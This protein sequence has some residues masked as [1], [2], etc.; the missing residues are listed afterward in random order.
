[1]LRSLIL[2][3]SSALLLGSCAF[4]NGIVTSGGNPPS[5]NQQLVGLGTGTST[6]T[7]V[8]GF[9]GLNKDALVLEAKKN[10]Y[11]NTRLKPNQA[12]TNFTVDFR[13]GFFPFVRRIKVT[14]AADIIQTVDGPVNTDDV[15]PLHQQIFDLQ[16][17]AESN[18]LL[19]DD[20]WVFKGSKVEAGVLTGFS[21][22]GNCIVR[23]T[24]QPI[25]RHRYYS[26]KSVFLME[27]S[28]ERASK[29][30]VRINQSVQIKYPSGKVLDAIVMGVNDSGALLMDKDRL[31][32]RPYSEVYESKGSSMD[33]Q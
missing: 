18:F 11:A 17:P 13:Y 27:I 28:E 19:G 5:P 2:L 31:I 12:F 33:N 26:A 7:Y 9:G 16:Q 3:A 32:V 4:H 29:Y 1:M 10:L 30:P 25:T 24:D 8:L 20:V 14:V 15:Q 22:Y 6:A 23:H 21:D